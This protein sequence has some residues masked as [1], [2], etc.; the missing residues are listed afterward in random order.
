MSKLGKESPEIVV[1]TIHPRGF[2]IIALA[3]GSGCHEV[4]A[5]RLLFANN[6][7]WILYVASNHLRFQAPR[8]WEKDR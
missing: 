3:L 2:G 7:L 5:R 4:L 1:P 6:I 8:G